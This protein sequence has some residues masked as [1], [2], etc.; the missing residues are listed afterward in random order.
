[1]LVRKSATVPFPNHLNTLHTAPSVYSPKVMVHLLMCAPYVAAW[2]HISTH[3][4]PWD[5]IRS[6]QIKKEV[7][8]PQTSRET[9]QNL[10]AR[11]LAYRTCASVRY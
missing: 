3:S 2:R 6:A 8:P 11:G 5:Q 10:V 1:M 7:Q 9:V 4:L